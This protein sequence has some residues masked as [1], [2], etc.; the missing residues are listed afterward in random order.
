M[1]ARVF[2]DGTELDSLLRPGTHNS[3]AM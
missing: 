1:S 2:L 3:I